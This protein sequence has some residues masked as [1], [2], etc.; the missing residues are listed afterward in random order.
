[1][2]YDFLVNMTEEELSKFSNSPEDSEILKLHKLRLAQI[3]QEERLLKEE[4]I[5]ICISMTDPEDAS[6]LLNLSQ[7]A[8]KNTMENEITQQ[9]KEDQPFKGF[10]EDEQEFFDAK[11]YK[12]VYNL[13]KKITS[14][15][16]IEKGLDLLKK[17]GTL[18]VRKQRHKKKVNDYLG[19]VVNSKLIADMARR[20]K[21]QDERLARLELAQQR[22]EDKFDQIGAAMLCINSKLKN[23]S[24]L[25]VQSKKLEAYRLLLE[26]PTE[27]VDSIA[28]KLNKGRAT[29]FR[30]MKEIKEL[31]AQPIQ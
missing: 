25:G 5:A 29:I 27:S 13:H 7:R 11:K 17:E 28:T 8:V 26:N 9:N 23:L 21:E 14:D 12:N 10:S 1:M 2:E 6:K 24:I 22:N 4:K 31:E 20:Q 16:E 3:G 15:P 30:W 19:G 18:D